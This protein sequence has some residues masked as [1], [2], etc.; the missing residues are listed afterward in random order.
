MLYH[1]CSVLLLYT[2]LSVYYVWLHFCQPDFIQLYDDDDDDIDRP[3]VHTLLGAAGSQQG[4]SS[5]KDKLERQS[6]QESMKNGTQLW[7]GRGSGLDREEWHRTPDVSTWMWAESRSKLRSRRSIT[8]TWTLEI[9][10]SQESGYW[11]RGG[12]CQV[13]WWRVSGLWAGDSGF[14]SRPDAA[15]Q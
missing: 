4:N 15:A 8:W 5:A 13:T 2:Y 9:H 3:P 12:E 1:N 10:V 7:R 11:W 6:Q 14:D